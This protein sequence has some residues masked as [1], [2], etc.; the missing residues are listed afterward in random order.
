MA[1]FAFSSL[2][3]SLIFMGFVFLLVVQRIS[4]VCKDTHIRIHTHALSL[5]L[6]LS[7]SLLRSLARSLALSLALSL[8]R[9]LALSLSHT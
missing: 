5:S 9:S 7:L 2:V 1:Q 8:S 6:S 4:C 3:A